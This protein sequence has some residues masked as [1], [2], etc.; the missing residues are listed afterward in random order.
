[1]THPNQPTAEPE[2]ARARMDTPLGPL[3]IVASPA[4]L[5]SIRWDRGDEADATTASAVLRDAVEQLDEYFAGRRLE[6]DLPLDEVGTEFQRSTWAVLRTIPYGRTISYG[7][8]A[9]RLG[10]ARKARAVGG[11]NGRNPLS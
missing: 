11:A 5:R 4:G 8:Q 7:E 6:F 2:L 9:G 10:D 3:T 1:M